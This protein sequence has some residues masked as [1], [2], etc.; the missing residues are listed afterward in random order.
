LSMVNIQLKQATSTQQ[1]QLERSE[2]PAESGATSND[3]ASPSA[4]D[5]AFQAT[6]RQDAP[7]RQTRNKKRETSNQKGK[8]EMYMFLSLTYH[9]FVLS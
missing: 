7:A 3:Q 5:F 8:T 6:P 2:N 1:S 9:A 4:S